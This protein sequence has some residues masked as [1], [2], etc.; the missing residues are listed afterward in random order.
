MPALRG[1]A[2]Q[3]RAQFDKTKKITI[4]KNLALFNPQSG[5]G[6]VDFAA[7]GGGVLARGAR[8][9]CEVKLMCFF[10]ARLRPETGGA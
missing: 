9:E 6:Y 1:G 7:G 3:Q 8:R 5:R 2:N 10:L 4:R